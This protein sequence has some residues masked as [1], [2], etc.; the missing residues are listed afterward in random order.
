[1]SIKLRGYINPNGYYPSPLVCVYSEKEGFVKLVYPDG[2]ELELE[3]EEGDEEH[4]LPSFNG[5]PLGLGEYVYALNKEQVI[6]G[7][8]VSILKELQSYLRSDQVSEHS[9]SI[10]ESYIR[11]YPLDAGKISSSSFQKSLS[12][13][14]RSGYK[15][16]AVFTTRNINHANASSALRLILQFKKGS[17]IKSAYRKNLSYDFSDETITIPPAVL[18]NYAM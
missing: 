1:M 18:E 4:I 10:I 17:A 14:L 3:I 2:E 7:T 16:R 8:H 6:Q 11:E 15:L 13:L 12:D 5:T 9:R